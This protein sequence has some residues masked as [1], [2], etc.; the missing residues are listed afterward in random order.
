[1]R[2]ILFIDQ[3][4]RAILER[5][6][7]CIRPQIPRSSSYQSSTST[8]I[9]HPAGVQNLRLREYGRY[10]GIRTLTGWAHSESAMTRTTV[11]DGVPG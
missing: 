10:P 6:L 11:R 4:H 8:M 5:T 7:A 9:R 3:V 2:W 1:M